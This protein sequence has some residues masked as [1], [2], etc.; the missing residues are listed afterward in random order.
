VFENKYEPSLPYCWGTF[1][2]NSTSKFCI[3][4]KV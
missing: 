2:S 3:I 4:K 1:C